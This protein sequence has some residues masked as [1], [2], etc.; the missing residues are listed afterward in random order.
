[1]TSVASFK[2]ARFIASIAW[3][4]RPPPGPCLR[5]GGIFH[6][7]PP[8]T[9][10]DCST[11][12]N[13]NVNHLSVA[14]ARDTRSRR[15]LESPNMSVFIVGNFLSAGGHG[16]PQYCE[17]FAKN[18]AL[19]GYRVLRASTKRTRVLRIADMLFTAV[20]YRREYAAAQISVFSGPAFFWAEAV[21]WTLRRLGKPYALTLHGGNLPAFARRWPGRV[22]RL[23][24]SAKAVTSPS[25]YLIQAMKSY[26]PRLCYV[27]NAICV[28]N[29][30]YRDH[31]PARL[32]L[33]W[34]RAFH[35]IYNPVMAV[36]VLSALLPEYPHVRLTMAGSDKL[37]GSF[38]R[39]RA[40]VSAMRLGGRVSF[41]GLVPKQDVPGVLSQNDIFINTANIDNTPVSVIE[42]LACGLPVV[43]TNVGG[44][45]YLL[46]HGET[47]LLVNPGDA[48]AM[49]GAIQLL[50]T[51]P[52]LASRLTRNGRKLVETFDW[53]VVI[54]L[55]RR[56]F[57]EVL[58][59]T[60]S[61]PR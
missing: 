39:T 24:D 25:R 18:L 5:F 4:P 26:C 49:A 53:N 41:P 17:C 34:L 52:G 48:E 42:A 10:R 11:E 28:G 31:Q 57:D 61:R 50:V 37:D 13:H 40:E 60:G 32:G 36:R 14:A 54:P 47:G 2:A 58:A 22:R 8:G 9:C 45:P 29:Y 43:S 20:R 21:A 51:T 44:M 59:K 3:E 23:L 27:P 30:A 15:P 46:E 35:E 56:L 16:S 12:L 33:I 7:R 19:C 6:A 38:E 55:W 1:V